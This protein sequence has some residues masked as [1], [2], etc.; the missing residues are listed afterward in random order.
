MYIKRAYRGK[1]PPYVFDGTFHRQMISAS[2]APL[3]SG[4]YRV[5]FIERSLHVSNRHEVACAQPRTNWR[6]ITRRWNRE[7]RRIFLGTM[8]RPGDNC[9]TPWHDT[10]KRFSI[11]S[12]EARETFSTTR[13]YTS[14][15]V[16]ATVREHATGSSRRRADK[17]EHHP[18]SASFNG[19]EETI[20][21]DLFT[22]TREI[23]LLGNTRIIYE[24][25]VGNRGRE[26]DAST[27]C[28]E[29]SINPCAEEDWIRRNTVA[30]DSRF[31][32]LRERQLLS[33]S[34]AASN[35]LNS[36]PPGYTN[37]FRDYSRA[38]IIWKSRAVNY[39]VEVFRGI[40]VER[41]D[42]E[43]C[44]CGMWIQRVG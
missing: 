12:P 27:V 42:E 21:A 15:L 1:S 39:N 19:G 44:L 20:K 5:R 9:D 30:N 24:R 41:V 43:R 13:N 2:F 4:E 37:S 29:S 33:R 22:R 11:T 7:A 34:F 38:L 31:L 16:F 18:L 28:G 25:L 35:I 10:K 23:G 8:L 32:K 6:V 17:N 26:T 40:V 3:F 14:E 36:R